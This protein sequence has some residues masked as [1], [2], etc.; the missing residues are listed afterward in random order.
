MSLYR[1][2]DKTELEDILAK[3]RMARD[4]GVHGFEFGT[5]TWVS[6]ENKANELNRVPPEGY[7]LEVPDIS[8]LEYTTV[9][10]KIGPRLQIKL[11]PVPTGNVRIY[12]ASEVCIFPKTPEPAQVESYPTRLATFVSY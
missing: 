11:S 10:T 3:F 9:Q 6:N 12:D 8:L 5:R 7:L 1:A 4:E 2:V